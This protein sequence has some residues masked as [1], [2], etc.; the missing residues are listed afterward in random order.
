MKKTNKILQPC[1][2]QVGF[3][4]VELLVVISIIGFLASSAM[5][6]LNSARLNARDAQ[7]LAELKN[8]QKALELYYDDHKY[9]PKIGSAILLDP[10]ESAGWQNAYNRWKDLAVELKEYT[11]IPL[12]DPLKTVEN[13]L[14]NGYYWYYDSDAGDGNQS[15][16]IRMRLENPKY[17]GLESADNGYYPDW[18]E[19][20]QQ[21]QYC[22]KYTEPE[23]DG[24]WLGGANN[25]CAGGN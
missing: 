19:T 11:Q 21:P 6:A 12:D 10:T 1:S 18:Y 23:T 15:Y 17:N 9:Y 8:M 5:Y 14:K 22:M 24:N 2:V 3:T 7:R 16:G 20:G 4:L 25:V 13:G